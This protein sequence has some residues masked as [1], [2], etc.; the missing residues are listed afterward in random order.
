M[1]YMCFKIPQEEKL[2]A[3]L[4]GADVVGMLPLPPRVTGT[5]L[6]SARTAPCVCVDARGRCHSQCGLSALPV[7]GLGTPIPSA[8]G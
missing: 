2:G 8:V 6:F 1:C 5:E 7:P 3:G 4:D